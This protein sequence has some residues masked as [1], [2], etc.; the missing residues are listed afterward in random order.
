MLHHYHTMVVDL[1]K[2]EE[3]SANKK[4]KEKLWQDI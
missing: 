4:K 1:Q 2:E 3:Y